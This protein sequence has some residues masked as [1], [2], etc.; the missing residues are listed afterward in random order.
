L[1]IKYINKLINLIE[2]GFLDI[3]ILD[4]VDILIVAYFF[5]LIYK[6]LR[7]TIGFNIII[8]VLLLYMIW[9]IVNL[10][11][12]QLLTQ[13]LSKFVAFGVIILIIIFQP[14]V[15]K[16]LIYLGRSTLKG[17]L[18][19]FNRYFKTSFQLEQMDYEEVNEIKRAIFDLASKKTGALILFTNTSDPL[20]SSKNGIVI[21]G[22][23]S[24]EL[25]ESIFNKNS[26][27]H[28]GAIV[29]IKEKIYTASTIL[30]VSSNPDI[31]NEF[32]TRHRAAIG[33]TELGNSSVF[34]VSEEKG[35]VTYA[36]GGKWHSD[37]NEEQVFNYLLKIYN[38]NNNKNN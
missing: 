8:G 37:L 20:L 31:P 18:N 5:Y 34:V 2:I 15:R 7:G 35:I 33:A 26:S 24:Y 36:Y 14:E 21:D 3:R 27:L 28:D 9:W 22:K 12:M 32:G 25:I 16:F 23:I 17:R 13:L 4:I 10:L 11:K 30:P 6:L 38:I 1:I 29:I 19:F